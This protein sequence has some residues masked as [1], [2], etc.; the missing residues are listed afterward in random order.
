M[1][2]ITSKTKWQFG[3]VNNYQLNML[4]LA[5]PKFKFISD[6]WLSMFCDLNFL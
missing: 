1:Y 6:I 2:F 5:E 4:C 3:I